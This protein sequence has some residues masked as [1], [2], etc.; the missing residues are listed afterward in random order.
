MT[1]VFCNATLDPAEWVERGHTCNTTVETWLEYRRAYEGYAISRFAK[2][3]VTKD[4]A[5]I[6]NEEVKL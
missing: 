1:C 6:I 5:A 2:V 3:A 4:P